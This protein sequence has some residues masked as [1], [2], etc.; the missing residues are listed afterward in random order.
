MVK[1]QH[2][3]I[4][5]ETEYEQLRKNVMTVIR[6]RSM[7]V[8]NFADYPHVVMALPIFQYRRVEL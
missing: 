8:E 1:N 3:Y 5:Q 6:T 4:I 2:V 7:L